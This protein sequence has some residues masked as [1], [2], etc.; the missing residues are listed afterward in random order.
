MVIAI[1]VD[2]IEEAIPKG[3]GSFVGI[4]AMQVN[5]R[6]AFESRDDGRIFLVT[7]CCSS[8]APRS[9]RRAPRFP[10]FGEKVG[11]LEQVGAWFQVAPRINQ[12][13]FARLGCLENEGGKVPLSDTTSAP[14]A[15]LG[16]CCGNS[17][18]RVKHNTRTCPLFEPCR[19]HSKSQTGLVASPAGHSARWLERSDLGVT[20]VSASHPLRTSRAEGMVAG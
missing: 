16:K 17:S 12:M 2:E 13:Q 20:P 19:G 3:R 15:F 7:L 5:V 18:R 4:L 10:H 14:T 11:R 6:V 9:P 8:A 1:E